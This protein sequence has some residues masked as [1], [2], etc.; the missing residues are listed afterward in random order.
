MALCPPEN[1][2]DGFVESNIKDV[3]P[4]SSARI[5]SNAKLIVAQ[6]DSYVYIELGS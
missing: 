3:Q 1:V 4:H 2:P 6:H 5:L